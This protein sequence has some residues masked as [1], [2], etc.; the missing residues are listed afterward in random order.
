MKITYEDKEFSISHPLAIIT[1]NLIGFCDKWNL[2][3]NI[4]RSS[5][6]ELEFLTYGWSEQLTFKYQHHVKRDYSELALTRTEFC[7][8]MENSIKITVN[9]QAN[10]GK[11]SKE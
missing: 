7:K 9:T 4:Y 10:T 5:E 11:Y 2:P 8:V 6:F 3:F 1:C